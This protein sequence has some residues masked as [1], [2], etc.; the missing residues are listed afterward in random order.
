MAIFEVKCCNFT[1]PRMALQ[2]SILNVFLSLI[3]LAYNWKV[4][5]NIAYLALMLILIS[6]YGITHYYVFQGTNPFMLAI[7]YNHFAPVWLM[8]GP[9]LWFYVRGVI[10]DQTKLYPYDLL[11]LLLPVLTL[12]G[13][14]PYYFEPF[15]EKIQIANSIIVNPDAVRNIQSNFLIPPKINGNLRVSIFLSYALYTLYRLWRFSFEVKTRKKLPAQYQYQMYW[16]WFLVTLCL[17]VGL[18]YLVASI[19]FATA[20]EL[21]R[22][23]INSHPAVLLSGAVLMS[24]PVLLLTNPRILYGM[25]QAN[26]EKKADSDAPNHSAMAALANLPTPSGS[27]DEEDAFNELADRLTRLMEEEKPFTSEDF[28]LETLA[29]MLDVPKHHLY[30]VFN[31]ILN[32]R[33]TRLRTEYR[34]N[35]AKKLLLEAD[36]KTRTLD[37]I[38]RMSGFPSRSG[39]YNTFKAEVGCSPGEYIEQFRKEN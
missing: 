20:D 16:L 31:N 30:F 5:R 34:V 24:I 22:D 25:P 15:A 37:A 18:N 14:F 26:D 11:H 10:S 23:I 6:H 3:M 21:T 7:L 35:Y 4:N 27:E 13:V 8:S 32:T 36:L 1:H 17:F 9:L 33:F 2:I 39:F 28:S 29:T 19:L 12:I 38:G